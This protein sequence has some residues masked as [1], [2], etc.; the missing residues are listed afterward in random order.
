MW[1]A[2]GLAGRRSRAG[3]GACHG[4]PL[5]QKHA[6]AQHCPAPYSKSLLLCSL[7]ARD[8]CSQQPPCLEHWDKERHNRIVMLHDS[9]EK[10]QVKQQPPQNNQ[11]C[12]LTIHL[13]MLLWLC[14]IFCDSEE[15]KHTQR[16]RKPIER[17]IFTSCR[18]TSAF[19]NV[20]VQAAHA[21]NSE[22]FIWASKWHTY[23]L[24]FI[25][26]KQTDGFSLEFCF[27]LLLF[28]F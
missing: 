26:Q 4:S 28:F 13:G 23:Y 17:F 19:V 11:S 15:L 10:T 14:V 27:G 25:E 7:P 21:L 1:A 22:T 2:P 6:P 8:S 5:L 16:K 18:K 12:I 20:F 3:A 9:A 24:T